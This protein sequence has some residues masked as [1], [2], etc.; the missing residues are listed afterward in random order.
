MTRHA[1][2]W[3]SRVKSKVGNERKKENRNLII[4]VFITACGISQ[5]EETLTWGSRRRWD[6]SI[7]CFF[8]RELDCMRVC[9][10]RVSLLTWPDRPDQL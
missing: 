2:V 8:L 9:G 4:D 1:G 10:A 7:S 3:E 5:R 6:L